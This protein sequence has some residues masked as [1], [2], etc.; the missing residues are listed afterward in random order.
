M[1]KRLPLQYL[2]VN[3]KKRIG[4][5]FRICRT[6]NFLLSCQQK[7]QY[8]KV[9]TKRFIKKEEA[10]Q[11]LFSVTSIN[12]QGTID[13]NLFSLNYTSDGWLANL[14]GNLIDLKQI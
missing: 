5:Y 9:S 2:P 3:L 14:T 7:E 4:L 10:F 11:C 1:E 12:G 6:K 13:P 8:S